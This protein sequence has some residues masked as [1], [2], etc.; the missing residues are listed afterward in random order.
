MSRS[1]DISRRALLGA[2]ASLPLLPRVALGD[3]GS[4]FPNGFIW[5][6]ST[7]AAQIEGGAAIDGRAPSIWD[8]FARE[9]GKIAD[10]GTPEIA[11]DHYHR[12]AEDVALMKGLGIG[13]YR[14]SIA[15]PRVLPQGTGQANEAGWAFY[16]RLVDALL[17]TG[18]KPMPCLYHW[19]LPQA[20]Q[21]KG[22][23]LNRDS[24]AW[25]TEYGQAAMRR[26]GDRVDHWFILN[27]AAVHAYFGH[28]TGEHAPGIGG[29]PSA[30][31]TALHHQNLAQGSTLRALRAERSGLTLGTVLSLQPVLPETDQDADRAAAIRW[32][33]MW[34]RVTL[35]G[36]LRGAVPDVLAPQMAKIVKADDLA[37]VKTPIDLLGMN[38]YSRFTVRHEAGRLFDVGWG[39]AHADRFTAYGWPVEPEGIA[40]MLGE[41]KQLYGNPPVMITEN[42]AAYSDM[43][44][45]DGRVVDEDRIAFLRDHL[46]AL[47]GAIGAGCNVKGYLAWSLLD[48][49]EWQ[50]GYKMRFGLV[51]VDFSS[52]DRVPKA[53][54]DWFRTVAQSGIPA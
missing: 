52:R 42:G 45:R 10:G 38:Y 43:Q 22:G 53:S 3:A 39:Q 28:G 48:N 13:A 47:S 24:A 32:D 14:F 50:M 33:A 29:G 36:L 25:L 4:S 31:L 44:V 12:W 40:E 9:A 20:L 26:L 16:D 11:C 19:D 27:E 51:F 18:I 1:R 54:Y 23:W 34:N 37:L 30:V 35:D 6:V 8:V 7:S 2:A 49:F 5:G 15:W 17:A 41:L 21:E 46:R